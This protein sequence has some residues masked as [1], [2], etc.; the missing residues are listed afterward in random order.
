MKKNRG[1]SNSKVLRVGWGFPNSLVVRTL[2]FHCRVPGSILGR[3]TK[4]LRAM[5]CSQKK[6]WLTLNVSYE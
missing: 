2:C 3:E 1:S 4:I 5:Q 6:K